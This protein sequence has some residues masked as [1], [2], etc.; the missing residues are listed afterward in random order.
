[1]Y[2]FALYQIR[3]DFFKDNY[4]KFKENYHLCKS[5]ENFSILLNDCS[6][7][8]VQLAHRDFNSFTGLL[9]AKKKGTYTKDVKI[10]R[11]KKKNKETVLSNIVIQGR[12]VRLNVKKSD[13]LDNVNILHY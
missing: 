1:M 2:N 13:L 3:Q 4:L 6:Q 9:K 7:Q 10:P 5:N 11:Y 8:V 12:S